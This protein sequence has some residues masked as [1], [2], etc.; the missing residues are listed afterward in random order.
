[1]MGRAK[2]NRVKKAPKP[3]FEEAILAAEY[4]VL[5]RSAEAIG[6]GKNEGRGRLLIDPKAMVGGVAMDVDCRQAYPQSSR[7]DY[8][9]GVNRVGR[10]YAL[11]VEVH[12]ATASGVSDLERKLAWLRAFLARD[13]QVALRDLPREL[14]WVASGRVDIPQHLP[15]FKRLQQMRVRDGLRGPSERLTLR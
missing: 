5:A 2:P 14:H 7:W 12:H 10:Q 15:Q 6:K 13:K 11:F 3:S 1:M 9:F 4:L 8:V